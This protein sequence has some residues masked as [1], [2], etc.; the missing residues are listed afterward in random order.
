MFEQIEKIVIVVGCQR[1]GTTLIGQM[2]GA[3]RHALLLDETDVVHLDASGGFETWYPRMANNEPKAVQM[4][5]DVFATAK[6]KYCIPNQRIVQSKGGVFTLASG[7]T[8]LVLKAPNMTYCFDS[9][10]DLGVPVAIIFALRDPRA[11]IASM[12]RLKHIDFVGNQLELIRR[13]PL[14]V[15]EYRSDIMKMEDEHQPLHVKSALLWKIKSS[16]HTRFIELRLPTVLCKYEALVRS[17]RATCKLIAGQIG[18]PFDRMMLLHE[19]V[20]QGVAQGKTARNRAVDAE[21]IDKWKA[22]I[23]DI[24]EQQILATIGEAMERFGYN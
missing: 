1:S 22:S 14:L 18:I 7:I 15:S 19:T 12:I 23:S 21:S 6:Q 24:E 5:Q 17:K 16:L 20:Y 3:P 4:F 9:I 2:M 8:Q 11:V 13:H 10:T